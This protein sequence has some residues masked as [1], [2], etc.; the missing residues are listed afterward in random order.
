MK[1]TEASR[2]R[3]FTRRALMLGGMQIAAFGALAG[4]LYQLQVVE[5]DRYSILAEEN[6][7]NLQLLAPERG[8]LYDRFGQPLAAN[9]LNY[10]LILT[11]ILQMKPDSRPQSIDM[12]LP[13]QPG[14]R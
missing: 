7:I 11:G 4:R 5:S 9:Q 10:R 12:G 8:R 6:R 3:L 1:K 14:G 2:S 13:P